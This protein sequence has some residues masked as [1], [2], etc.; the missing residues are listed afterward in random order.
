VDKVIESQKKQDYYTFMGWDKQGV[1]TAATL[2]A[3]GFGGFDGALA[4]LRA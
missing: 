4:P 1:P 2:Q 3:H